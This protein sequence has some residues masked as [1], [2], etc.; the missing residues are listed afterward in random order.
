MTA[1]AAVGCAAAAWV[2]SATLLPAAGRWRRAGGVALGGAFVGATAWLVV[3][4]AGAAW[5]IGTGAEY[6]PLADIATVAGAVVA[7]VFCVGAAVSARRAA[8]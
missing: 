7:A 2:A 8:R 5:I 1:L 4:S 6:V 3:F